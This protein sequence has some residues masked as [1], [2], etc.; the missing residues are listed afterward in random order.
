MSSA[1]WSAQQWEEWAVGCWRDHLSILYHWFSTGN[2][3]EAE[4]R[5]GGRFYWQSPVTWRN[6]LSSFLLKLL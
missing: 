4:N 3:P 2:F 5:E 6:S 1:L